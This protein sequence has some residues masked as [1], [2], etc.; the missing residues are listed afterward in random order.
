MIMKTNYIVKPLISQHFENV[1]IRKE[2][3]T[4]FEGIIG[5]S[6]SIPVVIETNIPFDSVKNYENL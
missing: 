4:T 5:P 2:K 3:W 6:C 1:W